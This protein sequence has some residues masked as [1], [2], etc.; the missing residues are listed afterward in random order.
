MGTRP[1]PWPNLGRGSVKE[2][3]PGQMGFEARIGVDQ[4]KLTRNGI[5]GKVAR[6]GSGNDPELEMSG[7][8]DGGHEK[9]T[10][11]RGKQ[12]QGPWC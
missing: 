9:M 4:V 10:M 3:F 2:G 11:L 1:L 6:G 12:G 8:K 5:S 7:N